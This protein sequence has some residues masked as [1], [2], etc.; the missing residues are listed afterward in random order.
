VSRP[1]RFSVTGRSRNRAIGS[2]FRQGCTSL[3]QVFEQR[4]RGEGV[5]PV[6]DDDQNDCAVDASNL[7]TPY[8]TSESPRKTG[9]S[10]LRMSSAE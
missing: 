4:V 8:T 3:I 1:D 2:S 10:M 9:T 7:W 5:H 6:A